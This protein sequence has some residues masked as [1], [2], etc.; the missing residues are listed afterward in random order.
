[1]GPDRF[2]PYAR[3]P[4]AALPPRS[5]REAAT[6]AVAQLRTAERYRRVELRYAVGPCRSRCPDGRV[7]ADT[8]VLPAIAE[9][10][11]DLEVPATWL[12]VRQVQA[13]E[14]L[15][16]ILLVPPPGTAHEAGR[17]VAFVL[18]GLTAAELMLGLSW[19]AAYGASARFADQ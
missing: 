11:G 5:P 10:L 18:E 16:A 14:T 15:T 1:M 6:R 9:L 2:T 17:I 3:T 8:A 7:M 12:A 4:F 19:W 13:G